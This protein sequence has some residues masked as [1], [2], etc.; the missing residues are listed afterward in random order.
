M[1][2]N[3]GNPNGETYLEKKINFVSLFLKIV[4]IE[5]NPLK[6]Q[7]SLGRAFEGL[8]MIL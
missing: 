7:A 6:S 4:K 2:L 3:F 1:E 8:G 5:L